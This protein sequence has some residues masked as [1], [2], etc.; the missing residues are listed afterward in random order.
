[1]L[2]HSVLYIPDAL[3]DLQTGDLSM[4]FGLNSGPVTAGLLRG[5]QSR[6]QLF[7]DT[8]NT[9]TLHMHHVA[10]GLTILKKLIVSPHSV[11]H[12][13]ERQTRQDPSFPVDGRGLDAIG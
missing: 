7:G 11:P 9:G 3:F 8:V 13:I 10:S 2:G 6:F 1:M 12:G 4:R 5:Q